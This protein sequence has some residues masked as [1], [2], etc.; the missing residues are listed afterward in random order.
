MSFGWGTVAMIG[1]NLLSKTLSK[2]GKTSGQESE[3]TAIN[4]AMERSAARRDA[5]PTPAPFMQNPQ[6]TLAAEVNA[7]GDVYEE[8]KDILGDTNWP[9]IRKVIQGQMSP[10]VI[11]AIQSDYME[12][13][14]EH[15][16]TIDEGSGELDADYYESDTH[17]RNYF[18]DMFEKDHKKFFESL[19]DYT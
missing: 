6:D 8:L 7:E 4:R 17:D 13:F 10:A 1:A 14:R 2:K 5:I 16:K 15:S 12:S 9:A 11:E 18:R 3:F 19:S